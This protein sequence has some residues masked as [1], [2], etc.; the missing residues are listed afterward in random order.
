M[1]CIFCKIVKNEINAKKVYED[2]EIL[3]FYDVNPVT[4]THILFI[5]KSHIISA[6]D[7][8]AENSAIIGKIFCAISKV[9]KNLP[10]K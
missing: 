6:N 2:D 8:N 3:A 1:N 4:P 7:I 5:P 9:A 10:G